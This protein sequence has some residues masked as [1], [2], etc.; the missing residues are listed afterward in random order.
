LR[1]DT[2]FTLSGQV[3][4]ESSRRLSESATLPLLVK[5]VDQL[6]E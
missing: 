6:G 2:G 4:D 3:G 5:A 1:A